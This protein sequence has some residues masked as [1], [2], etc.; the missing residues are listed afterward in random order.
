M[1][2]EIFMSRA[3]Q[4]AKKALGN[5]YPNPLVGAVITYNGKVIGEGHHQ[6]A[7]MPHAEIN[8]INSVKDKSLLPLSTIYVTLE[9]CAHYG[10]TPPCAERIVKEKFA[11][12]VVGCKDPFAKVD[13]KGMEMIQSNGIP[14]THGVLEKQCT[15]L[16]KRFFTFHKEKRPFFHLKWAQSRDGFMDK[17]FKQ[18]K[19]SNELSTQKVHL[20]RT[21]EEAILVGTTTA[22]VDNPSL[23]SRGVKG[24]NPI[25]ILIDLEL[26]VPKEAKIFSDIAPT[27]ILNEKHEGTEGHL[28]Y[29]LIDRKD[30]ISSLSA[31]LYELGIQSVLVEGGAKTL[32][33]FIDSGNWDEITR[34]T[35]Q[36]KVLISGTKAPTIKGEIKS[37]ELIEDDVWEIFR[38]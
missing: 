5:T 33:T 11:R 14:L 29:A 16:N 18:T 38:L 24:K 31:K 19:I 12:V 34:I 2:D 28:T 10:K 35:A 9:P 8:A 23:N 26:K 27:I 21:Q 22:L 37:K 20:L 15:D 6:K 1:Q 3:I 36:E 32:Q 30:F 17:D 7:G 4:L 13:G 25:R